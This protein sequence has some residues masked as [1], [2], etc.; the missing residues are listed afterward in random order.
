MNWQPIIP[1][2]GDDPW[3]LSLRCDAVYE[4]PK[5]A[6]GKRLGPLV[7]YAGKDESG[8]NLVGDL[9]YNFGWIETQMLVVRF[10]AEVI[11]AKIQAVPEL[12]A[13][14]TIV[15]VPDG[16]RTLGGEIAASTGKRFVYP[17]KVPRQKAPGAIKEEFDFLFKRNELFGGE[18][19]IVAEDVQNNFNNSAETLESIGRTGARVVG[20]ASALNRSPFVDS[21]FTP[22]RGQF[23]GIAFPVVTAIRRPMPEY[24]QDDPEV[25]ADIAAGNIELQ[26]KAHWSKLKEIMRKGRVMAVF[27]EEALA[28]QGVDLEDLPT[29]HHPGGT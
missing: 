2:P 18:T 26:V 3:E 16:G 25:A 1:K 5:S 22:T 27:S 10:F 17:S 28:L 8:L 7:P 23:S 9:Y 14:T 24:K 21:V 15:G 11:A 12:A 29:T 4:C 20:F 19:V 13:A 6:L